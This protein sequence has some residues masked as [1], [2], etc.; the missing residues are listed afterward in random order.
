MVQGRDLSCVYVVYLLSHI[1]V[2]NI[3]N[4]D[5]I[6][7]LLYIYVENKTFKYLIHAKYVYD[8]TR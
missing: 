5:L 4:Y 7:Q 3:V 1:Y 6:K 8:D 2:D